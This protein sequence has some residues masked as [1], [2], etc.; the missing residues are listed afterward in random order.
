MA[1]RLGGL[2]LLLLAAGC[3]PQTPPAE[4]TQ[5]RS[6]MKALVVLY[7]RYLQSHR[8]TPPKNVEEFQAFVRANHKDLE[9]FLGTFDPEKAFVSSRDSQP[10]AWVFP[11]AA[12]RGV[13]G[14]PGSGGKLLVYEQQGVDGKR[15]AAFTTMNIV[16]LSDE[17]L[18]QRL[19]E[20]KG[21]GG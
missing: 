10:L 6:N 21:T 5:S 4:D 16:E 1:R 15:L 12:G 13:P 14:A 19:T 17:E 20:A 7:Q 3:G 11:K 9:N 18:Q 8:G 2:A